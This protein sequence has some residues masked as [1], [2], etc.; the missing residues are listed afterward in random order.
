VIG[1]SG[2]L[3]LA[4]ACGLL[5]ASGA[6]A[7]PPPDLRFVDTA[8]EAGLTAPTWCGGE[9]KPHLVESGGTG[10]AL[11]D[12]DRDGDLDLYLVN[13]WRLDGPR[14]AE[15]GRDLLYRNRGDGTFDDVTA[16][17]SLGSDG[18][19]T[20][21]AAG[22]FDGDGWTDLLVTQLGPDLV[23]RN[24]GDGTF[25]D[26]SE[27]AGRPGIDGW[28]TGAAFFDA[29]GD[30]DQD[31]FVAGYVEATID[32]VLAAEPGLTWE[33]MKV[34]VGP[35]GL[36]G[37]ANRYFVNR[38]DGTF[39]EATAEAGLEDAG[40]FFSF[41]A[42]ALDLDGD[43]DV[44]LYVANDSNP[45][46]LYANDGKGRFREVGLW[47]GAALSESGMA[48]AGMGV[49]AGDLDGDGLPDLVVTNFSNDT[50]T[51]YRNLGDLVF[52]D[53]SA[54]SGL[55]DATFQP[56]SWGTAL[57]DLD[58]D[59]DLDLAVANG[60]IYPQADRV[61]KPGVTYGQR[62]LVLAGEGDRFVDATSRAGP[63]L[64]V[65]ASSRGLAAG[66]VDG[67]G[68][69]DLAISNVDAPPTL[70]RNDSP[71]AGAWLRVDAPWALRAE[72]TAA[73]GRRWVGHRVA[74]GSYVS[75]GDD[76]F[77]FGLGG[78]LGE[79]APAALRLVAPD[80]RVTVLTDPPANRT[81]VFP[82]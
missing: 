26:V 14:V 22:D 68:D 18:W 53:A 39:R 72:V 6:A 13:G 37:L 54:P 60:H 48:Q 59:G 10:L 70:L 46:Y 71:A 74:G 34:M 11:V 36:E 19:G 62:N 16:A 38:G 41:V 3:L 15:R 64:T 80:G 73:D 65:E 2:A 4:A 21:V 42:A 50:T 66:D 61:A 82:E 32:Q 57:A 78:G 23:Y 81:L 77:H 28:S 31:L 45:N 40:I 33:G 49:A 1:R 27:A 25:A 24:R 20:G 55:R 69:L 12:Y 52:V 30:G 58:L 76:R 56:L 29:D 9:E 47:S 63:G 5:P 67:D 43:L 8:A 44:D 79:R 7:G 51:L 75:V 35:F 17:A